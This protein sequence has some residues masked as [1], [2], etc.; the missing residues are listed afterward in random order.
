MKCNRDLSE[1]TCK[2]L[3][4]KLASLDNS[5]FFIY[6]KCKICGLHYARCE[7][8][9]PVWITSDDKFNELIEKKR[10]QGEKDATV[11]AWKEMFE[12]CPFCDGEEFLSGPQG[13]L[14]QNFMCKK[15]RTTFNHTPF[16]V[17]LLVRGRGRGVI[18][19]K[20]K[21]DGSFEEGK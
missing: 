17:D 3:N 5:K 2:D 12:K 6:R 18:E 7:C 4:E 8:E 10:K 20:S 1:C 11:R 19:M 9:N 21:K 16:G 13:G 15:C 14:S